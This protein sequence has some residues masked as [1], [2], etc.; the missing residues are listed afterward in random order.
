[1]NARGI[2]LFLAAAC[3][4]GCV[5][6]RW[7]RQKLNEQPAPGAVETL[8]PGEA[9]LAQAL[10]ALGAP[11]FVW[12]QP[13]GSFALAYGWTEGRGI[14]GTVSIPISRAWSPSY[15]YDD[16]DANLFGLVLIFD[17]TTRLEVVREGYLRELA[18]ELER[19]RPAD[20]EF[21]GPPPGESGE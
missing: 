13:R 18:A 6:G 12:E 19:Q 17:H 11:L 20:V 1:M 15:S 3:L 10:E 9:D 16:V 8:A 14:G 2:A 7:Q 21:L 5:R 4:S